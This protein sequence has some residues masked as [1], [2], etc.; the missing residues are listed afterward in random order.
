MSVKQT[1]DAIYEVLPPTIDF[2]FELYKIKHTQNI[3][4]TITRHNQQYFFGGLSKGPFT[5][6]QHNFALYNVQANIETSFCSKL[7]RRGWGAIIKGTVA[8]RQANAIRGFELSMT[9]IPS[10]PI[11]VRFEIQR[12]IQVNNHNFDLNSIIFWL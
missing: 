11:S 9:R 3:V 5:A 12:R 6:T 10:Q 1:V 4:K 7:I 8:V 2:E